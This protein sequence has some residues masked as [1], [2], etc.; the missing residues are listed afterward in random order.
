MSI[1][2]FFITKPLTYLFFVFVMFF[3]VYYLI[4][5]KIQWNRYVINVGKCKVFPYLSIRCPSGQHILHSNINKHVCYWD[6]LLC[7]IFDAYF[8]LYHEILWI[9]GCLNKRDNR[10]SILWCEK[11]KISPYLVTIYPLIKYI[12]FTFKT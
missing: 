9:V 8:L 2:F 4:Q 3:G 12:R 1:I 6:W 7:Q 5:R 11:W 10:I